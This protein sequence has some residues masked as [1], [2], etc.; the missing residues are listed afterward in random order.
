M[1]Q[2]AKAAAAKEAADK[3]AA[4]SGSVFDI[5]VG[6]S[7]H[8]DVELP[9]SPSFCSDINLSDG[10]SSRVAVDRSSRYARLSSGHDTDVTNITAIP[11]SRPT[12]TRS[13]RRTTRSSG[14]SA[15]CFFVTSHAHFHIHYYFCILLW[16]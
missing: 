3:F 4:T 16:F 6:P 1:I 7:S 15:I 9:A 5:S 11:S 13:A 2:V 10:P 8:P 12:V 14:P